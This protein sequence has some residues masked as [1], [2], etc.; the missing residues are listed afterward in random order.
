MENRR[1]RPALPLLIASMML[2]GPA[3]LD[4]AQEP[5][6]LNP[7]GPA[8]ERSEQRKDDSLP[9]FLEL[10]DGKV[11]PGQI[12]LTRDARLKIFD[13]SQ[14]KHREIPLRAIR[15][16][17]CSVLK[18]WVEEE[19]R[20]KENAS[21]EKFFTGRSYPARE[22]TH[23]IT[24]QN[25][26]SITGPLSGI[27]YVKAPSADEPERFLLHKR[28][29]G[30]PGTDLKALVY[31]RSIRLGPDALREGQRKTTARTGTERIKRSTAPAQAQ[32][33]SN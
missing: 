11:R 24:L 22:Y 26:Q 5:P 4:H 13:E 28:D 31:V 1:S 10:S 16:I 30:E 20:F 29:K 9:G 18:E 32:R 12:S 15:R 6:A 7:F 3:A 21:D 23:T 19:W 2:L 25:G 8:F 27:V 33:G 14:K 17:D